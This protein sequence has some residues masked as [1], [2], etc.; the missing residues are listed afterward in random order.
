MLEPVKVVLPET[1]LRI[2]SDGREKRKK[3][4]S[5][6]HQENQKASLDNVFVSLPVIALEFP[7]RECH[8]TADAK[9]EE[10]KNKVRRRAAHPSR[11]AQRREYM[12]PAARIIDD[13][14]KSHGH[15]P[16]HIKRNVSFL[17]RHNSHIGWLNLRLFKIF[18]NF[19]FINIF[20]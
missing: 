13:A 11:M 4:Q 7:Q 19:G 12:G 18:F 20:L 14:H 16:Q 1:P 10:R 6:S 9:Q 15:A 2:M 5:E 17:H 8:C 3:V